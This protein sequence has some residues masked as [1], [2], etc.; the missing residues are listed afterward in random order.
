LLDHTQRAF[1]LVGPGRAG[2]TLALAMQARGWTLRAVAGRAPDSP[3]VLAAS[4]KL[5]APACDI[6]QVGAH[7]DVVIIATPDAAIADAAAATAP[8]LRAGVLVVHLSGACTLDELDKLRV[9]RPDVELGSLHPLQSLPSP[10]AGVARLPGSWCAVA[11]PPSVERLAVSLG[12]RPFRVADHDRVGYHT[13]ATIASN[14]V[15]ALLAQAA[16]IADAAG[17]PP[18]ALVPLV[19]ATLDNVEELGARDALTGPVARGDV[20]TIVRHLDALPDDE[21]EAYI[22]LAEQARRLAGRDDAA[23]RKALERDA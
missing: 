17:V 18:A 16:R 4:T 23:L 11:G 12:M 13:A 14:H 5:G 22:A 21:R 20:D 6:A 19:R 10:E 7:A 9:A 3:S 15:V 8:G 1:A 2:T